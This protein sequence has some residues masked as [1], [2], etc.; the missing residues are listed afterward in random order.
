MAN[1]EL[2]LQYVWKNCKL[3]G[4]ISHSYLFSNRT[5][6]FLGKMSLRLSVTIIVTLAFL[7]LGYSSLLVERSFNEDVKEWPTI[8]GEVFES[9]ASENAEE[10]NDILIKHMRYIRESVRPKC[11]TK[12]YQSQKVRDLSNPNCLIDETFMRLLFLSSRLGCSSMD[13][14]DA[15]NWKSDDILLQKRVMLMW[16]DMIPV[17]HGKTFPTEERNAMIDYLVDILYVHIKANDLLALDRFLQKARLPSAPQMHQITGTCTAE[18]FKWENDLACPWRNLADDLMILTNAFKAKKDKVTRLSTSID[19]QKKLELQHM[20]NVIETSAAT[21]RENLEEFSDEMMSVINN[22]FEGLANYFGTLA[23]YDNDISAADIGYISDSLDKFERQTTQLIKDLNTVAEKLADK[24]L[25]AAGVD[26]AFAWLKAATATT[27]G[28]LALINPAGSDPS[29]MLNAWD[30]MDEAAAAT[31]NAIRAGTLEKLMKETNAYMEKVLRGFEENMASLHD[32]R[33]IIEYESNPNG[34]TNIDDTRRRFLKAYQDYTPQ[35]NTADIAKL[36]QGWIEILDT[37]KSSLD[38]MSQA[39]ASALKGEI[40]A[41]N[42]LEE[43][44]ILIPQITALLESQFEYQFDLMDSL[45]VNLRAQLAKDSV[46]DLTDM[47]EE[48]KNDQSSKFARKQASLKSLMVSKM[49]TLQALQLHCNALEYRNAGEMPTVCKTGMEKMSDSAI[50]DVISFL[51][52]SCIAGTTDGKYVNIPVSRNNRKGAVNIQDL[53]SGKKTTFQVPDAQWLVDNGWLHKFEAER[54]VFYVKGFELFVL[55]LEKSA[56]G[57]TVLSSISANSAAPLI[58]DNTERRKYGIQP[59][60]RYEFSYRENIPP[61]DKNE[62]NPYELCKPLSNICVVRDGLLKNKYDIYPSIFSEWEIEVPGLDRNTEL[63][64]FFEEDHGL[65]LQ[66]KIILC[67]KTPVQRPNITLSGKITLLQQSMCMEGKYF[68]RI[69][70][71]WK[72]CPAGSSLA[73]GGYYCEP[74]NHFDG[75]HLCYI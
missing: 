42:Y 62:A 53:F 65:F 64:Q 13:C 30:K 69:T 26:A 3:R 6:I 31:A 27:I 68:N 44:A 74:G 46:Q 43:M 58:K 2:Q 23:D 36:D 56:K 35:V 38:D 22:N 9:V 16:L 45:A 21:T 54:E 72:Q 61:C 60:Q 25:I 66:A 17:E 40:Y 67:S 47:I 59:T 28:V 24:T 52:Q 48:V 29:G 33:K 19:Y 15:P 14:S 39:V 4:F 41:K 73:L 50:A 37:I 7:K 11:P 1:R 55:S 57:R 8:F 32:A 51:P 20:A 63:P 34:Q 12:F 10:I 75:S 18:D 71:S 49:H 70:Q 5:M